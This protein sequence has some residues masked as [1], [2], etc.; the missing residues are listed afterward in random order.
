MLLFTRRAKGAIKVQSFVR[1]IHA[2]KYLKKLR[3]DTYHRNAKLLAKRIEELHFAAKKRAKRRT[4]LLNQRTKKMGKLHRAAIEVQRVFRGMLGRRRFELVKYERERNRTAAIS[5]QCKVRQYL[6]GKKL[7]ALKK[8][9]AATARIIALLIRWTRRRRIRRERGALIIQRF[10]RWLRSK[11]LRRKKLSNRRREYEYFNQATELAI[12][13]V[14]DWVFSVCIPD[15]PELAMAKQTLAVHVEVGAGLFQRMHADVDSPSSV[16]QWCMDHSI[17]RFRHEDGIAAG[18][19]FFTEGAALRQVVDSVRSTL[20]LQRDGD[21]AG[22]DDNKYDDEQLIILSK[23]EEDDCNYKA[24]TEGSIRI[25]LQQ[26]RWGDICEGYAN[27]GGVRLVLL[28]ESNEQTVLKFLSFHHENG[29]SHPRSG[30]RARRKVSD[31][32]LFEIFK[33]V[34]VEMVSIYPCIHTY[35]HTSNGTST[36]MDLLLITYI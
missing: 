12:R 6:A 36:L 28:R 34:V 4:Y 31:I 29:S 21:G 18:E 3:V 27:N 1:M 11:L 17:L 35:I 15:P 5:M 8:K 9:M 24:A 22:E 16:L 14:V 19:G 10:C 32:D 25:V 2:R 33:P 26:L 13:N 20:S 7:Q 23:L 30:H